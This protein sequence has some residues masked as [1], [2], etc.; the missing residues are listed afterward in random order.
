MNHFIGTAVASFRFGAGSQTIVRWCDKTERAVFSEAFGLGRRR[1]STPLDLAKPPLGLSGH[2]LASMERTYRQY[3]VELD[4]QG[5]NRTLLVLTH[6]NNPKYKIHVLIDTARDVVLE[7]A[8]LP[9]GKVTSTTKFGDFVQVAGAWWAT[10]IETFDHQGRRTSLVTQQFKPLAD[11]TFDRQMEGQ[12]AGLD[13]VQLIDQPLVEVVD[14]KQAVAG[15]KATF[16]DQ[17]ALVLHFSQTQQWDRVMEHL[18]AAEQLADGKPGVRWIRDA[19]LKDA[20]RGEELKK[21][22]TA[23]AKG[24]AKP[25]AAEDL[26]LA[27]YLINQASGVLEA[28]EMLAILDLLRPVYER[29]PKRRLAMKQWTQQRI[30]YL[31]QTGQADEVL[32]LYKK[33]ATDYP[34]DA[35]L[36]TELADAL[37]RRGEYQAAYAWLDRTLADKD[38]RWL[39]NELDLLRNTYTHWLRNQGR[40]PELIEFLGKPSSNPSIGV[41][42]VGID[43]V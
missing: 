14:A 43:L 37:A 32:G 7:T 5:E 25:K 30:N 31:Q 27:D 39:P 17:L 15:G 2:V 28:N 3:A 13:R 26:F 40:Y 20:R 21:R 4:P 22:I 34:R 19:V 10:Q 38:A 9:E 12:L 23:E 16:D 35:G 6:P 42:W 11:D 29:Q 36:Q 41:D 33:L 18:A 8:N 24:V 1:V